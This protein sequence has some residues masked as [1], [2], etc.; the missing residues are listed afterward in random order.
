MSVVKVESNYKVNA[1]GDAG[2]IGLFQIRPEYSKIRASELFVAKKNIKEG[3]R[4]LAYARDNC[5]HKVD[6]TWIVCY[7]RGI[8]GGANTKS[9]KASKYYKDV[10]DVYMKTLMEASL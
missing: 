2:E 5:K 3:L 4:Q 6:N 1:I 8:K 9:P 10:M 7:N